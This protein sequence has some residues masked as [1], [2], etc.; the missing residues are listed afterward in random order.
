MRI[1]FEPFVNDKERQFIVDGVDHYN[2]ASTNLP[3]YFPVNFILR[4]ECGDV[5]GGVLG[6][7]WGGW[8]HVTYLWVAEAARGAGYGT[9]LMMDAEAYARTRGATGATLETYSFQARPFY[10]RL[11]YEVVGMLEGHPTG[12]AKFFLR[13]VLAEAGNN[14]AE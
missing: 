3:N 10:E 1:D 9:R 7:L 4:G 8:L 5:L 6:E 13:K 2:I 11:G 12:H 14:R